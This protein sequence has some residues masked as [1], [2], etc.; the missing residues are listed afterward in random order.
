MEGRSEA[1][2]LTYASGSVY[3]GEWKDDNRQGQFMLR[4]KSEYFSV[5]YEESEITRI[6]L[7]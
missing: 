5:Q 7:P 1:W 2:K 3:E 6:L 4:K